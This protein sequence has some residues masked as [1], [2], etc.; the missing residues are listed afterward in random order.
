MRVGRGVVWLGALLCCLFLGC[1]D[2]LEF[3]TSKKDGLRI[4]KGE[5]SLHF[6]A[7]SGGGRSG[8]RPIEDTTVRGNIFNLRPATSR[9]IVVFV[10]VDLRDPGSFQDFRDAE[11]AT[12]REDRTFTVP[13]L[14]AG[15]LTVVFLLDQAG[16]NQDGTIDPGDPIAVFQDP[17]GRLQNLSAAAEVTLEDVDVAFNLNAPDTGIATVRS[18]ANI[19]VAQK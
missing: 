5:S 2:D 1:G 19:I 6:G 8:T 16:V 18:E 3:S 10:F 14:A 12:I 4:S 15:D 7:Q 17:G 13:H 9:P 11:V